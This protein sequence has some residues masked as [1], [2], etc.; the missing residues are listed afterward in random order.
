VVQV[1]NKSAVTIRKGSKGTDS[2]D[3]LAFLIP[4]LQFIQI[5]V[6][7][8]L[9]GADLMLLFVFIYLVFRGRLRIATPVGKRFI[10]LCSLWLVSQIVTDIVRHSAFVDYAR[11]WS[12]IGMTLVNFAVIY[13][14]L[15]GRPKRL[16]LYAG[17]LAAGTLLTLLINPDLNMQVE[18]WKFA[19][20]Y[21]VCWLVMLY[22]SRE[23]SR[24]YEPVVLCAIVGA[25]N[26][27]LGTRSIGSFCLIV[28]LYL[29]A[30]RF[31]HR[32]GAR[33]MKLRPG[34]IVAALATLIVAASG[35]LWTYA[36]VAKSGMLGEDAREKYEEQSSG[37]YG[38]LVGGRVELLG[39]I[40][41]IYDSPILGHGSWARDPKYL[42][43][44]RQALAT[45]GY[46]N[47]EDY[48]RADAESGIIQTHS[49]I[50][51][52]WVDSGILGAVFWGWVFL[53]TA[54]MLL[55]VYPPTIRL[56]PL[57][58]FAAF[59]QL[60]DI[61]FSPY[62]AQQRIVSPYYVVLIMTCMGIAASRQNAQ[63]ADGTAKKKLVSGVARK[64]L[65]TA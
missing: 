36:Y 40:P 18:P 58:S 44:E 9:N 55:S 31:I 46:K 4:C 47:A 28:A 42:I 20:A 45:M 33:V 19:I 22:A 41:A 21:P 52:A 51:G 2:G 10:V 57:A 59:T 27:A 6:I 64:R 43:I 15:Y 3:I 8:V 39:S 53:L 38:V 16:L 12:N 30:L 13:T 23:K 37:K 65:K 63:A 32:K 11:G 61:L 54:K 7:G 1:A 62:G 29:L 60:W 26:I 35:I 56:L 48:S 49:Y 24:G 5:N 14:L 25:V 34:V 50:F 17:G